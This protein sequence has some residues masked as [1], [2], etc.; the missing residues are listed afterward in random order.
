MMGR[1]QGLLMKKANKN[2]VRCACGNP[3]FERI[4]GKPTSGI[5]KCRICGIRIMVDITAEGKITT[6]QVGKYEYPRT[7]NQPNI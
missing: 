2:L 1:G 3:L 4:P 5:H 7:H 6:Q